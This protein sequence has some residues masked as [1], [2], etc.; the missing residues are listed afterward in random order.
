MTDIHS[1]IIFDVDDGAKTIDESVELIKMLKSVGFDSIIAT[2]HYIEDTEYCSYNSEKLE[3]LAILKEELAKRKIKVN[4]YLG[5]EIFINDHI[6]DCIH[7]G[8]AYSLDNG[9]YLL[10]EL[11][12]HNR[13]LGLEDMV[14]EMKVAGYT[15][16]LAHPER[17]SYFQDNYELVDRLKEE[18]LLF[19][20]NYGSILGYFGKES[21]KLLKYMI[22]NHYVDY[23]G[24]DIH[25]VSRSFTIDH[26]KK[27][28]KKF[29]KLAG[30]DYY[31]EI[32]DNGDKLVD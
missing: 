10:F 22:K 4:L 8:K 17:Y 14:Y 2:P 28:E 16:I 25:H 15:P 9:K 12:F 31:Q 29:R 26:F 3:K 6:I 21:E 13:I 20:C 18:G 11:P 19:Q 24:T 7:E 23:L 27:I 30:N 32:I 5:N 1:H